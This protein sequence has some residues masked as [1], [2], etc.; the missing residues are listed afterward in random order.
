MAE[1]AGSG[2][3]ALDRILTNIAALDLDKNLIELE[4]RG[5]TTIRSVLPEDTVERAKAAILAR[6]EQDSGKRID[7]ERATAEDFEGMKYIPYLLY[8]HEVFEEI[9]LEPRPL[10]LITYLLGESCILSSLG[11]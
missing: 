5:Y 9:L 10:A 2:S 3:A 6:V 4:T 7:I 11:C 1:A 8:D